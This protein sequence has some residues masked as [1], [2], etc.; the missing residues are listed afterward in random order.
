MGMGGEV[1]VPDAS[2]AI[3]RL[4]RCLSPV[5][6]PLQ[7]AYGLILAEDIVSPEDLPPHDASL[8]VVTRCLPVIL[9]S[10]MPLK[11][12]LTGLWPARMGMQLCPVME[13]AT[14]R[15]L[16]SPDQEMRLLQLSGP[17]L[18]LT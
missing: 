2:A 11:A 13:L 18:W 14:T 8:K 6:L 16:R 15:S 4:T 7:Q 1:T 12:A 10:L 17:E 3:L 9:T 5:V